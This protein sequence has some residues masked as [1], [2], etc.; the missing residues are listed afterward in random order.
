MNIVVKISDICAGKPQ[1]YTSYTVLT[2]LPLRRGCLTCFE[3]IF[4]V[5]LV[6]PRVWEIIVPIYDA[7][8]SSSLKNRNAQRDMEGLLGS[9]C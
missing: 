9:N 3:Y 8:A 6:H 5:I 2:E 7:N 4:E 1:N